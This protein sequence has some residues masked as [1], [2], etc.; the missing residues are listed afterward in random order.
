MSVIERTLYVCPWP[1]CSRTSLEPTD[2]R[3]A[4]HGFPKPMVAVRVVPAG[5]LQ[6]AVDRI[7]TLRG[8][9]DPASGDDRE[10]AYARGYLAAV[11][12]ALERLGGQ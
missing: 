7:K 12:D 9:V 2:C 8:N 4:L 11:T 6:G 5:Q 1:D 10:S 3:G